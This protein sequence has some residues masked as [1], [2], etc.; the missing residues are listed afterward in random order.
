MSEKKMKQRDAKKHA[1]G[2]AAGHLQPWVDE[3]ATKGTP[4]TR[5]RCPEDHQKVIDALYD[6][7]SEL[8]RR[9]LRGK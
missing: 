8:S 3:L 7:C 1:A 9:C 6:L 2:L 4:G 5:T